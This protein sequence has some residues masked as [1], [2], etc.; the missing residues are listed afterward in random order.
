MHFNCSL[1]SAVPKGF[2]KTGLHQFLS[3]RLGAVSIILRNT[4]KGLTEVNR[5]WVPLISSSACLMAFSAAFWAFSASSS[6][7][8][9]M[10]AVTLTSVA[11][12][13]WS[14]TVNAKNAL[15][16]EV[17]KEH[18]LQGASFAPYWRNENLHQGKL[19]C[20]FWYNEMKQGCIPRSFGF[21]Q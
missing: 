12:L 11:P 9:T 13:L 16:L 7:A 21:L 14:K 5:S 1:C 4:H 3:I 20:I 6:A 17:E 10:S 15:T 18:V 19:N 8:F 2:P